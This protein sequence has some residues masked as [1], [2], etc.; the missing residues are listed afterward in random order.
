MTE[1]PDDPQALRSRM[2]A[3][4]VAA[5]KARQPDA[6]AALRLVLAAFD[7][8]EAVLTSALSRDEVT[9]E[10]VAGAGAGLGAAEVSRRELTLDDLH[11]ILRAQI[12]EW[13]AEAHALESYGRADAAARSLREADLVRTYLPA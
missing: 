7:N 9:S 12:G 5:M 10:F 13:T 2:R 8:A 11:D 6:V 3:D 4:L 1:P